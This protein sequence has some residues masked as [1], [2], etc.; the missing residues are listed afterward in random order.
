VG[1]FDDDKLK[2]GQ[3]VNNVLVRGTV[4]D[5]P[6]LLPDSPVTEAILAIPSLDIQR[7]REIEEICKSIQCR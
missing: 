7:R 6:A 3:R 5:I 1:F 2:I 4:D